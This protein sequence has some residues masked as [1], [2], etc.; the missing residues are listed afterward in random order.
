[1]IKG[2]NHFEYKTAA[3]MMEGL[4]YKVDMM[5]MPFFNNEH[6]CFICSHILEH[7]ESDDKAISELFRILK[8][9]GRGI[10]MAPIYTQI[11][12]TLEDPSVNSDE[13]RWK[14][15]GQNDH[16]RLYSHD[17]FVAKIEKQ[18]FKINQLDI[19][20]FGSGI[21]KKLGLKESSILYIV[22]K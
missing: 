14:Y 4:E 7:V 19:D 1:M 16:V 3:L 13:D 9:Q 5:S 22:E 18:G 20:Y 17:G 11:K 15:Y 2:K 21:F 12:K 6:D 8:P 10:L